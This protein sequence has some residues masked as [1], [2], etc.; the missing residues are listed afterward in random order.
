MSPIPIPDHI[1]RI[2]P[3]LPGKPVEE[4]ERELG[5]P[6]TVKLASNENPLGAS[7]LAMEAA[8]ETLQSIHRYPDGSGYYLRE[9]LARIHGVPMDQVILG[10]GS[11][12]LVEILARTFLG[13]DGNAVIADQAFIMYRLA[14]MA[15]NG[16]ARMVPLREMRHDLPAMARAVDHRTRLIFVAN[17][18]NPTG[19]Y[20]GSEEVGRFLEAVPDDVL[21]VMDEAYHE[22]V[23]APDYPDTLIW[24]RRGRRLAV[25]RTFSKVYGLAGLRLGYAL[26]QPDV[27]AAAE[28]VR[29]PFNTG[30]LAQAAAL[31][32]LDDTAHVARSRDHNAREMAFLEERLSG[33][34]VPFT[35]SVANFILV[36]T[37]Q[38]AD[39]MFASLLKRGV[40]TRSMRAFNFPRS[41]RVTVGTRQENLRFLDAL[42]Q[43]LASAIPRA[44]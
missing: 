25:L 21:V 26:T 4:V 13:R 9:K 30:S 24:L 22:Y 32:A 3:Y 35:R 44:I 31:A 38:D 7:P 27:R 23:T 36:D 19:T 42:A 34:Q 41:L 43:E 40:I 12:D 28:K 16:N 39:L 5:L 33:L 20:V 29:S 18:N 15:V 10:N 1:A 14:V 6:D 8:R 11:T 2:E 17:P 37:G